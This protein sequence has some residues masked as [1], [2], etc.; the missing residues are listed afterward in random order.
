MSLLVKNCGWVVTQN[1][2]REILADCNIYVE[3]GVV[4][5]VG[6][7]TPR[8]AD[9]VLDASGK[10]VMPGLV[11]LHTH[12][13][14]TLLRG[15]ADDMDLQT[16]LGEKIWPFEVNLRPKD[17]YWASLLGLCEMIR[18]G[19]TCFNDMYFYPEETAKA[20]EEA[21]L[22]AVLCYAIIDM[23]S[24]EKAEKELVNA[25]K[26]LSNLSEL[27]C[28]R[29]LPA[30]GPHAPYTCMRETLTKAKELSTSSNA[31]LHIHVSET[32]T[33]VDDLLRNV[34]KPPVEYLS[35]IG[36][37]DARVVIA[38]GVWVTPKEQE[39]LAEKKV[40]VAHC[41][42]SN[43][44]LSSGIAPIPEMLERGVLVGLGTDGCASNNN[45][46][47][48]EEMK[49]AALLHKCSRSDPRALPAQKVLDMATINGAK[50]C[51]TNS[52]S[53]EPGRKAD[54]IIVDFRRVN[55]TPLHGKNGVISHLVYACNGSNVETT[56]VDGKILMEKGRLTTLDEDR[57]RR[58]CQEIAE[59]LAREA[60]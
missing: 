48:F 54:L 3:D 60:G 30:I 47:M 25:K 57:I 53:I 11:N 16:W 7:S 8:E 58:K 9:Q 51:G 23:G 12:L 1:P 27:G 49:I 28:D 39:I 5:E 15:Y 31:M 4:V 37:L 46:D 44:K 17:V 41:P 24:E 29:V 45:L 32:R 43:M 18:S 59:R 6:K 2:R 50:L 21:G 36:F 33:E 22:R 19:T 20:V 52:G 42:A 10:V 40:G 35:S 34:G 13:A 26:F 14:M 56:I 38:H 55:T